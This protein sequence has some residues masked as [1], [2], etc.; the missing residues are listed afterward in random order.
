MVYRWGL[1]IIHISHTEKDGFPELKRFLTSQNGFAVFWQLVN[2]KKY[3]I[4]HL[5]LC[6]MI[7]FLYIVKQG[8]YHKQDGVVNGLVDYFALDIIEQMLNVAVIADFEVF[9]RKY[10]ILYRYGYYMEHDCIISRAV[11][12]FLYGK[13]G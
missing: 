3:Q 9:Y 2:K 12:C 11:A 6:C 4:C 1:V 5:S 7:I 13:P 8:I 10:H